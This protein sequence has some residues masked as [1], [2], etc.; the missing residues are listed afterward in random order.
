MQATIRDISS[1]MEDLYPLY[2]AEEWDNVG[3]QIGSYANPVKRIMITLE[4]DKEIVSEAIQQQIDLIITHHPLFFKPIKAINFDR[5]QGDLIR[6]L[7]QHNISLY[8]AH[9]N[10]D[11]GSTGLNQYLAE[12]LELQGITLLDASYHETLYKLVVYVPGNY[13][14]QVRQSITN[15]GAGHIGKYSH[16]TFRLPGTGTFLPQ[17]GSQPFIGAQG[18][19]E[20]VSEI[21]LETIVP[22]HI[23]GK[24]LES[25]KTS[26]PYE[27]VAYDIY[28]LINRNL[29]FSPGRI[30]VLHESM[31]L[32]KFC[33]HVKQKLS[34]NTLRI[35]GDEQDMIN[36]IALVSGSGAGFINAA[37]QNGCDLLLTGDVKYH[38][39]KDA[40]ALGLN[41]VDAGHQPMERLMAPM[42]AEQL[43]AGCAVKGYEPEIV[44][45]YSSECLTII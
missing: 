34:I 1:L 19:L 10:L 45:Q 31:N 41:I 29:S 28:P 18:Q 36:K 33:D 25:M 23:L 21:R 35:V 3:L 8:A 11:A 27:E 6:N 5:P 14:V 22:Q 12:K 17:E 16:C 32:R 15:A 42:L 7:I 9:T 43:R 38:E 30:G 13:E 4:A 37:Y 40:Q 24:V 2:I 44:I 20:E 39:A 26:H